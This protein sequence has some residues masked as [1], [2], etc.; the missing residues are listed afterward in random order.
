MRR[1]RL[2][3]INVVEVSGEPLLYKYAGRT[4]LS[5]CLKRH[6]FVKED[7]QVGSFVE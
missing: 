4:S 1:L 3:E 2:S 5:E 6:F 7:G